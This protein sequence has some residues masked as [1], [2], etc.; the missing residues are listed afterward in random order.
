MKCT[1]RPN[2]QCATCFRFRT[3]ESSREEEHR[4]IMEYCREFDRAENERLTAEGFF[5]HKNFELVVDSPHN[6]NDRLR[7]QRLD[8]A[9]AL[10]ERRRPLKTVEEMAT[11]PEPVEE[12]I[13]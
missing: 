3:E 8:A 4:L 7:C 12:T 10:L 6:V 5:P 9:I 11:K 13:Q 2:C 1:S